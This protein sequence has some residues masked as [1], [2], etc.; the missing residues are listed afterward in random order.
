MKQD[1]PSLQDMAANLAL[2]T[3]ALEVV[4]WSIYDYNL[5]PVAGLISLPFFQSGI[6]A[7]LSVSP[8][9]A[10]NPKA[11]TDTNMTGNGTL[12]APQAFYVAGIEVE[13]DPGSSAT[14]NTFALQIPAAFAAAGAAAVQSG[15]TDVNRIRQSGALTFSIGTKPYYTEGP[16]LRFPHRNDLRLS[17][18]V[19]TT[20]ATVGE[21]TKN[22]Y[23]CLG[24][25]VKINPGVG[26]MTQQNFSVTL[27]WPA[28]VAL[29][30]N[31]AR[32][33]V[34]LDGYLFRGVQ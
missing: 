29:P 12:P 5:Y 23:N 18:S 9:N 24:E 33:G 13:V 10:N 2:D 21:V 22:R 31:N 20:S 17:S 34:I 11:L 6:G 3:N 32:I 4:K 8:G 26:I 27:S 25:C 7:G 28:V 1:Y 16:L 15:E 19:T 30:T 14:A